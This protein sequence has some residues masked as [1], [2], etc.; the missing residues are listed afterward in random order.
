MDG[1][2]QNS[3][4]MS[5]AGLGGAPSNQAGSHLAVSGKGIAKNV[6]ELTN[7]KAKAQIKATISVESDIIEGEVLQHESTLNMTSRPRGVSCLPRPSATTRT[8]D[9]TTE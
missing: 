9:V 3:V 8:R 6:R 4:N 1:L 7:S 2:H 5:K